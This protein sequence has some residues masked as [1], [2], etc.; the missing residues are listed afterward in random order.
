MTYDVILLENNV[1]DFYERKES[2]ITYHNNI[3]A[4]PELVETLV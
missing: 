2:L 4:T 3:C 1:L